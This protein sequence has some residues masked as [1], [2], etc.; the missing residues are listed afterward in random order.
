MDASRRAFVVICHRA[1]VV[2]FDQSVERN[3][4]PG[5]SLQLIFA[6]GT[7]YLETFPEL[8][9]LGLDFLPGN[10][11]PDGSKFIQL[12]QFHMRS[13]GCR[14]HLQVGV[15][16]EHAAIVMAQQSETV[17]TESPE[18]L[19][20]LDPGGYPVPGFNVI[21]V[22]GK[23]VVPHSGTPEDT[24][25]FGDGARLAVFQPQAGHLSPVAKGIDLLVVD[26]RRRLYIEEYHRTCSL[27]RDWK[28]S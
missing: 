9:D 11:L 7:A 1:E 2:R 14:D 5:G 10:F 20:R 18:D 17:A 4:G 25:C 22:S 8:L 16:I 15:H 6:A 28:D 27:L 12:K 23:D 19:G 13:K 21:Q 24:G 26:G 3:G